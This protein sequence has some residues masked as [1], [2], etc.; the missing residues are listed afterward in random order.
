M[1][2]SFRIHCVE[3]SGSSSFITIELHFIPLPL[4]YS[5]LCLKLDMDFF[6]NNLPGVDYV[7]QR[8]KF[9]FLIVGVQIPRC[10]MLRL[11]TRMQTSRVSYTDTAW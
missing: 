8:V 5:C 6:D 4:W 1:I 2:S 7:D 11:P 10:C 3:L 9:Y